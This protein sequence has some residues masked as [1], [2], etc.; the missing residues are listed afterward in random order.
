[1]M[2][3]QKLDEPP[4]SSDENR[5]RLRIM[6]GVAIGIVYGLCVRIVFGLDNSNQ[7]FNTLTWSFLTLAPLTI[8]ALNIYFI[9]E[10]RK[11]SLFRT[12]LFP[13]L[14][15][16]GF[17]VIVGVLA[18][19]AFI[20]VWMAS[21]FFF[22]VAGIGGLLMRFVLRVSNRRTSSYLLAAFM[23]APF[24][25]SPLEARLSRPDSYRTVATEITIQAS[26]AV[27]WDEIV[28]VPQIQPDE[29]R[30]TFFQLLGVPQPIAATM[31]F[32]GIGGL[33]HST[34]ENGMAFNEFV[35]D[36]QPLEKLHFTIEVDP[37]AP[38]P[39][40][41]SEINGLYFEMIDGWY[42]LEPLPL[43]GTVLRL[44]S[45]HRLS[46]SFNAYGGLWTDGILYDLQAYI[47]EVIKGRA[48]ARME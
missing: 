28:R 14:S 39:A 18:L 41:F 27:I 16:V 9:P 45:T 37:S 11:T 29:R 3:D 48:E 25:S 33:R 43:G 13:M 24:V 8:G 4:Q 20:C 44:S 42:E 36:W 6:T 46:T 26:P 21:P 31:D 12:F 38:L 2:A 35:L 7:W 5:V 17:L 34:Y 10:A 22:L 19:E 23:V 47:L 32:D 40:P 1:M 30:L 15:C